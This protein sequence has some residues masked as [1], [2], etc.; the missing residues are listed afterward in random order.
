MA[1]FDL[2][3]ILRVY[4]RSYSQSTASFAFTRKWHI[5]NEHSGCYA[6]SRYGD[7]RRN[8]NREPAGRNAN[9]AEGAPWELVAFR[10]RSNRPSQDRPAGES[11][12]NITRSK[13]QGDQNCCR[14]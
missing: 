1:R 10:S 7:E 3:D 8:E 2:T 11:N 12:R 5:Q 6:R 14:D 4:W 13:K 9:P